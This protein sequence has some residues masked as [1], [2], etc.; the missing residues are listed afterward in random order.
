MRQ[1][2]SMDFNAYARQPPRVHGEENAPGSTA[3]GYAGTPGGYPDRTSRGVTMSRPT[4]N[5]PPAGGRG[6]VAV[7]R[8]GADRFHDDEVK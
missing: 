6:R 1:Q 4:R 5:R 7:G 2:F 8:D 3:Y